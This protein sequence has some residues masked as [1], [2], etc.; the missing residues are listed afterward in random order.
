MATRTYLAAAQRRRQLLDAASRLFDR[1]G[2]T[3]IT[4]SAV[5]AE[6]GASRRLVYDHF[7]DLGALYEAFFADRVA[8]YATAVDR[9][10]APT[11]A[12]GPRAID[13]AVRELLALPAEVVAAI[14]L[15]MADA[16]TPELAPARAALRT[17]LADRW[18]PSLV[19]LGVDREA[20]TALLW[21]TASSFVGLADG[22]HRGEIDRR[23]AEALAEALAA[24]LPDLVAR[25]STTA[26][27]EPIS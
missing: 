25:L 21:S 26:R 23:A 8:R 5:A 12:D 15:L 17:H 27:S 4:M 24:A 19:A 11:G 13:G 3:A 20:A 22:V 14:H 18:L 16:S 10:G 2:F 9:A 7:A 6:A 1:G